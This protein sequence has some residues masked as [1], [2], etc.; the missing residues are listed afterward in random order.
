[1]TW[2]GL[3]RFSPGA[4]LIILRTFPRGSLLQTTR[5][6]KFPNEGLINTLQPPQT[7]PPGTLEVPYV[8]EA[9][10]T[11]LVIT[12]D[13]T[14]GSWMLM[15]Q[16]NLKPELSRQEETE[17]KDGKLRKAVNIDAFCC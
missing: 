17:R 4:F 8:S 10:K 3:V 12:Q 2:P 16:L 7:M 15:P 11:A 6:L 13:K 5:L 9:G 14:L 1:M